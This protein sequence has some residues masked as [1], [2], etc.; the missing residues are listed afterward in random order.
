MLVIISRK[1]LI[2]LVAI[3]LISILFTM[4]TFIYS[5][6]IHESNPVYN[7]NIEKP[8]L[9]GSADSEYIA[10][11]CNVDWGNEVLPEM[12]AVL[13]NKN[14]KITF[15]VTGRWSEKYPELLDAIIKDGHEIA[16]HGHS[17]L[18]YSKLSLEENLEQIMM[19]E[20]IITKHTKMESKLFSSPAGA[21]NKNTLIA[22][23]QLGYRTILWS[24]DTIDWRKGSTKDVIIRRVLEKENHKGAIVLM[25][26]KE[27]TV[28][29]L[30]YLI[31]S[32]Q[33]MGIKVGRVSDVLH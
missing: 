23:G 25:H 11:A 14:V 6:S 15:F 26:P 27:E 1:T 18:N 24:I 30:E 16:S 5:G 10:F 13:K 7:R 3:L 19:A 4:G 28:K 22:A 31:D 29:A 8:I 32:L 20:E 12:L 33:D 21:Y 17:H 2:V 9:R